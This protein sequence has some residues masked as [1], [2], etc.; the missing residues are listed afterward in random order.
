MLSILK[1]KRL[2]LRLFFAPLVANAAPLEY[3]Y[4]DQT[5]VS[6]QLHALQR[7]GHFAACKYDTWEDHIKASCRNPAWNL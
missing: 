1:H 2:I 4:Y 7:L 6:K 3:R 5:Y